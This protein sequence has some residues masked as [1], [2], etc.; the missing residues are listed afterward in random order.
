MKRLNVMEKKCLKNLCG[1]TIRD[2]I[3]NEEIRRRVD[4][5][6]DLSG[7]V[8]RCVL[9]WFGHVERMNEERVAKRA[10]D[11]GVDGRRGRGRPNRVWMDGVKEALNERGLTLEQARVTVHERAEWRRL[12]N[13]A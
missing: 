4:V 2:R 6:N 13:G 8:G 9:R 7:R 1:V 3:R 5:Q 10:Y 12:V 11:S